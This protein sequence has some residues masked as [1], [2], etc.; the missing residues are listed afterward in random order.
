MKLSKIEFP[1][2]APETFEELCRVFLPRPI[3]DEAENQE[4]IRVMDWIAVGAQNRG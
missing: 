3:R 4:M 2:K 1:K